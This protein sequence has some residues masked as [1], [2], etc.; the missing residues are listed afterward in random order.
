M[1]CEIAQKKY[2]T[3]FIGKIVE[4]EVD[5][6]LGS[7]HPDRKFAYELNYG[8]VPGTLAPD[9]EEIDAYLL[10]IENP[11]NSFRG[12]C[13]AVIHRLFD[14][15]DKLIVI[16]RDMTDI[17]DDEIVRSTQFQERFFISRILRK[18]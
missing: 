9:G 6:P 1:D 8:F 14:D 7:M 2:A 15:D 12:R 18:K 16:P 3:N 5:R 4:I 10:G 17:A 13:V 11:V